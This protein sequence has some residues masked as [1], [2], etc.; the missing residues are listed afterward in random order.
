M[1]V[2]GADQTRTTSESVRILRTRPSP[3]PEPGQEVQGSKDAAAPGAVKPASAPGVAGVPDAASG[4]EPAVQAEVR[5]NAAPLKRFNAES[6]SQRLRP[7]RSADMP[8][9]PEVG[10]GGEAVS[11][12]VP[13]GVSSMPP[14]VL[15]SAPAPAAP[16]SAPAKSANTAQAGLNGGQVQP[17]RLISRTDPEYPQIAKQSGAQGEVV[18]T[19]RIGVDGKVKDV[20]V[21]SGP[22]F[23]RNA[24]IMAVKKWI[25]RPTILNGKPIEAETRISLNFVA[26]R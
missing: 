17:A 19:A 5:P 14:P 15:G 1:E 10:R 7:V 20:K 23:L 25:Y 22:P 4:Q 21:E 12:S 16:Q 11:V 9:A 6:L 26:R 3:M 2:T 13:V 8:D 18:L 24:A